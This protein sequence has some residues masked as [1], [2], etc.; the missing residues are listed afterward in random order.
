[1]R[2]CRELLRLLDAESARPAEVPPLMSMG[3]AA[4]AAAIGCQCDAAG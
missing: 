2:T 4:A 1:V 3:A